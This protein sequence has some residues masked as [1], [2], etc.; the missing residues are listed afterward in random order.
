MTRGRERRESMASEH[1]EHSLRGT[2]RRGGGGEG[3]GWPPWKRRGCSEESDTALLLKGKQEFAQWER[4]GR[5]FSPEGTARAETQKNGR[6]KTALGHLTFC[7]NRNCYKTKTET[8]IPSAARCCHFDQKSAPCLCL[9]A[10]AVCNGEGCS[11][12]AQRAAVAMPAAGQGRFDGHSVCGFGPALECAQPGVL[13]CSAT[14]GLEENKRGHPKGCRG[15]QAPQ[16]AVSLVRAAPSDGK[17]LANCRS[18]GD[19]RA[20]SWGLG[21]G[22]SKF[23]SVTCL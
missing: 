2:P 8:D 15:V 10:C 9:Q 4:E 6:A 16:D 21:S 19:P 14:S 18:W 17:A 12:D 3:A 13:V 22:G 7:L 11:W 20:A 1:W 23:T 5:A